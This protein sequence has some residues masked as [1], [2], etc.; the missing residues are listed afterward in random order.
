LPSRNNTN[1]ATDI[2]MAAS[3]PL[4][5]QI[6]LSQHGTYSPPASFDSD[7]GVLPAYDEHDDDGHEHDED[8]VHGAGAPD[9]ASVRTCES[10]EWWCPVVRHVVQWRSRDGKA[11]EHDHRDKEKSEGGAAHAENTP[12]CTQSLRRQWQSLSLSVRFGMIRVRRR[13][14]RRFSRR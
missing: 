7:A 3:L 11:D 8:G 14:R 9:G 5:L 10:R 12:T 2:K 1:S 13:V 4:P 6:A